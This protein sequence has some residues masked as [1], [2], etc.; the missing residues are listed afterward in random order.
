MGIA[1]HD[2]L[3]WW[4]KTYRSGTQVQLS[5]QYSCAWKAALERCTGQYPDVANWIKTPNVKSVEQD[6]K[7]RC[8]AGLDHIRRYILWAESEAHLWTTAKLPDGTIASEVSFEISFSDDYFIRGF[9]DNLE[10][11]ADGTITVKDLK[12]GSDDRENARQLAMYALAANELFGFEITHGRYYYTKLNRASQWIDLRPFDR[13]YLKG[14]YDALDK[15]IQSELFLPNPSKKNCL[16]C[17]VR[18]HCIEGL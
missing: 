18:E 12:T 8:K 5:E 16:F 3:D 11:W 10:L 6:L 4:E 15:A 1:V 7:L 17:S 9:I 2:V 13:A 14:Q